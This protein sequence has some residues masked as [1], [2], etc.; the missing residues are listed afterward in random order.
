MSINESIFMGG[1][2]TGVRSNIMGRKIVKRFIRKDTL[3]GA[4]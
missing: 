2:S 1:G 4:L 3:L